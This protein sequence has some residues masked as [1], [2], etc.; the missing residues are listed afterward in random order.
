MNEIK[1]LVTTANGHTGFPAAKEL[2]SLGFSV[3]AMVRNDKNPKAQELKSL[4]AEIFIGDMNDLRDI[5]RALNGVQRVYFCPPFGKN[6]LFQ[7]ITFFIAAEESP[8]LE[9]V[10][11]MSQWLLSQN[12]PSINT[13][14]QWLG[15]QIVKNHKNVEYTFV[16]PG[17]FGFTYFFTVEFIAQL[18]IMP[19]AI[20]GEGL[21][22]PP[23]E[24]DQGRVVAH[25]LKDPAKHHQKT[26]RPTGP[27]ILSQSE[28]ANVFSK[29]FKRKV[30]LMPISE[31]ML[32]KSLKAG[33]YSI[34]DYSNIR[35]YLQD[36][37]QNVF[38]IGGPTNVVK[39]LTG[40]E[41]ED[42]E[43]TARNFIM[44]MPEAHQSFANKLK[45]IKNFVKILLTKAP[46]MKAFEE[47]Q[48]YPNF[49]QGMQQAIDNEEWLNMRKTESYNV[50]N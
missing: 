49:I 11:Y 31:K 32:L 22:V 27:K 44:N 17:M 12:H 33:K 26:Y 19:T 8:Q 39:E 3:R 6:T 1:I 21:N 45:A 4:G 30:K 15:E 35:Y 29:I 25:I 38:A 9:H 5:K 43:T 24:D 47:E 37:S 41:P 18:G 13:K 40:R 50:I 2:I 34:Y 14:M 46:N 42:F 16:N 23:S 7:T 20:K 28:V 48:Y 36:A 10:V